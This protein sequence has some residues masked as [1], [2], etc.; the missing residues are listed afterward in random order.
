MSSKVV[1]HA[2]LSALTV[3]V[4][5]ALG[6]R[7]R[8]DV[9]LI[10]ENP[11]G[12]FGFVTDS[13]HASVWISDGCVNGAGEVRFCEQADGV[14]LTGTGYWNKPGAAAIPAKL[15]FV[16]PESRPVTD[17]LAAWD[18]A[19]ASTYPEVSPKLGRKYIGRV[20]RRRAFACWFSARRLKRIWRVI[21][22]VQA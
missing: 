16:G 17:T 9:G 3:A 1:R 4:V 12:A 7:A 8:A 15:Y 2:F 5:L 21:E 6:S 18:T 22:E 13:G 10:L 11:D 19:L 20:W 14:V